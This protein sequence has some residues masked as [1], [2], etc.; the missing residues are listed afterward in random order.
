MAV[1][2]TQ[3]SLQFFDEK[4]YEDLIVPLKEAKELK[5]FI[6]K[7]IDSYYYSDSVRKEIE[8]FQ[9]GEDSAESFEEDSNLQEHFEAVRAS[10]AGWSAMIDDLDMTIEDGAEKISEISKRT[11]GTPSEDKSYGSTAFTIKALNPPEGAVQNTGNGVETNP[12]EAGEGRYTKRLDFLETKVDKILDLLSKD[13]TTPVKEETEKQQVEIV[14]E[15]SVN[16]ETLVDPSDDLKEVSSESIDIFDLE[17][18]IESIPE[19]TFET[20]ELVAEDSAYKEYQDAVEDEYDSGTIEDH[21]EEVNQEAEGVKEEVVENNQEK[22]EAL[23][24]LSGLLGSL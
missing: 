6:M 5:G 10:V 19:E 20:E 1:R 14:P 18:E 3:F 4:V 7:L 2:R 24:S 21:S 13:A 16:T 12:A 22:E 17:D 9:N 23:S 11:G 15:E 8:V